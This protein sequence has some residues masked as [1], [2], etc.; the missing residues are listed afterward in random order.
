MRLT[1]IAFAA[2]AALPVAA[3]AQAISGSD[4]GRL[5]FSGAGPAVAINPNAGLSE[6]DRKTVEILIRTNDIAKY[7]GVIAFS[8]DEGLAAR[9]TQGAFNYH[10]VNT[11][12]GV[13]IA[14]CNRV[15][16]RGSRPCI[17]AAQLLPSGY[18]SRPFQLSQ[19]ATNA[20]AE[21]SRIPGAKAMAASRST[22]SFAVAQGA[23]ALGAA[24]AACNKAAPRNDCAIVV[25]D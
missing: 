3:T 4:A 25:K 12:A 9:A 15:R 18:R 17:V 14:E 16:T 6:L 10:D 1:L 21:Y 24:V 19:D 7:Y 5:L 20:F 11:A 22:G 8:P 2:L 13:A 23:T